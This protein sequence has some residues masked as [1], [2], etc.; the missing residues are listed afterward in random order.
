M[1]N[2]EKLVAAAKRAARRLAKKTGR[3]YQ[4]LLDDIARN[5][6]RAHWAAFLADP[7]EI[8]AEPRTRPDDGDAGGREATPSPLEQIGKLYTEEDARTMQA[9][10]AISIVLATQAAEG[11][12]RTTIRKQS[13]SRNG[14]VPPPRDRSGN[15]PIGGDGSR[16]ALGSVGRILHKIRRAQHDAAVAVIG[17]PASGKSRG[18]I[19]PAILE[20]SEVNIVA[21][22]PAGRIRKKMSRV[23]DD[24]SNRLLFDLS[25]SSYQDMPGFDPLHP[26]MRYASIDVIA[27]EISATLFSR[28][29]DRDYFT[30]AA[31]RTMRASIVI[32]DAVPALIPVGMTGASRSMTM[33]GLLDW[34]RRLPED[35]YALLR[36]S[37]DAAEKL[38]MAVEAE[39]LRRIR[40]MAD[41]E[42]SGV[43]GTL[44]HALLPFKNSAVR[45]LFE[46]DTPDAGAA[47]A[48][49][50]RSKAERAIVLVTA[51]PAEAMAFTTVSAL[52][53][54]WAG[55]LG[56]AW[57]TETRATHLHVE[58][59]NSMPLSPW[60][61]DALFGRAPRGVTTSFAMPNAG[62]LLTAAERMRS[63][64]FDMHSLEV[65]LT[66]D[67]DDATIALLRT[68]YRRQPLMPK[69][70]TWR[71]V[72]LSDEGAIRI[73]PLLRFGSGGNVT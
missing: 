39:E 20:A 65:V 4:T 73:R 22:D 42:R 9:N 12:G 72:H 49:T 2:E 56:A 50:M 69:G 7:V 24:C 36:T 18:V 14:A 40:D 15:P 29:K 52:I 47:L 16:M 30:D 67:V 23:W 31:E 6:G 46:P 3:P 25:R 62:M 21:Y 27:R 53:L 17:R 68:R 34:F 58:D 8:P 63:G 43:L 70:V 5:A 61:L 66:S 11:V 35:D 55:R 51:N 38:G 26:V 60:T 37:V 64:V 33:I 54:G 44:D 19:I 71:H 41:R 57:S 48:L 32:L 45:R 28:M 59:A 1:E 13:Y 10:T